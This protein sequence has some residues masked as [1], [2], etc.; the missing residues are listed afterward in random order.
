MRGR[1]RHVD[2]TSGRQGTGLPPLR[3]H[4]RLVGSILRRHGARACV[5]ACV[6]FFLKGEFLMSLKWEQYV[7]NLEG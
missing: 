7:V 4:P 3:L 6:C 5:S 1:K 2:Y